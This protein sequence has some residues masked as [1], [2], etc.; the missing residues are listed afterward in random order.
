MCNCTSEFAFGRPNHIK[1]KP[2]M[3]KNDKV[4]SMT[5]S[6]LHDIIIRRQLSIRIKKFSVSFARFAITVTNVDWRITMA[7]T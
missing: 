5:V 7:K 2:F 6:M 4:T 3:T 1:F